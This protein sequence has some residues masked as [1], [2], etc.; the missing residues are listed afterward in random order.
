MFWAHKTNPDLL[1][2]FKIVLQNN[3]INLVKE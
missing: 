2:K 1:K 3:D